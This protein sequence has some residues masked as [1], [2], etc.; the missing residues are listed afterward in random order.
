M[1]WLQT[2]PKVL[3]TKLHSTVEYLPRRY[4]I[5]QTGIV[6]LP[7]F[8]YNFQIYYLRLLAILMILTFPLIVAFTGKVECKVS[9]SQLVALS[10]RLNRCQLFSIMVFMLFAL[11]IVL[12][13]TINISNIAISLEREKAESLTPILFISAPVIMQ[14]IKNRLGTV[15]DLDRL[16]WVI[17]TLLAF[18]C[19]TRYLLDSNCFLNYNCRYAAKT[20]GWFATTNVTGGVIAMLLVVI[21]NIFI[22]RKH[23]AVLSLVFLLVSTMSRSAILAYLLTFIC[24]FVFQQKLVA[25][26][27][28]GITSLLLTAVFFYIDPAGLLRDGSFLSK[29]DFFSRAWQIAYHSDFISLLL[30]YG[31]SYDKI[32]SIL[33][34]QGW[35]PHSPILKS[36]LYYGA[37]G[38]I[39][40]TLQLV[41]FTKLHK[42]AIFVVI[43]YLIFAFAGAPIYH[44]S[45]LASILL[46]VIFENNEAIRNKARQSASLR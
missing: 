8:L 28:V 27:F 33:D 6:L 20:V 43:C 40:F 17:I 37:F 32:V 34:V 9:S 45:L 18:E 3:K 44:P 16:I 35:S 41:I 2:T 36:F 1:A 11:S 25:R 7:F 24:L 26:I 21:H 46:L 38:L 22:K 15:V 5:S 19:V 39:V 14:V 29:L 4:N 12:S 31:L 13:L 42:K 23:L 10:R 30:G